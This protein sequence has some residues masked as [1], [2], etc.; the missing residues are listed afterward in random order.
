MLN[1]I[2]HSFM[3]YYMAVALDDKVKSSKNHIYPHFGM[4]KFAVKLMLRQFRLLKLNKA[5]IEPLDP[6]KTVLS[7][8]WKHGCFFEL[9]KSLH[10]RDTW[11]DRTLMCVAFIFSVSI[12]DVML[13]LILH[14]CLNLLWCNKVINCSLMIVWNVFPCHFSRSLLPL[15][16]FF[17]KQVCLFLCN[18]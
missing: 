9:T 2:L 8:S 17:F 6:L 5:F 11:F 4:V 1:L 7:Q 18:L 12:L 14:T 10:F 3:M 13:D 15:L 16:F